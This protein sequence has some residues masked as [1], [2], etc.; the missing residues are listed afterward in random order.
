MMSLLKIAKDFVDNTGPP[1][2]GG[3]PGGPSPPLFSK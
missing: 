3:G 1:T 2:T